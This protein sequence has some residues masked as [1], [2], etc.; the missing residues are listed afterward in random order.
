MSIVRWS[1]SPLVR[2][3]EGPADFGPE[4]TGCGQR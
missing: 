2:K 1:A 3:S 4:D